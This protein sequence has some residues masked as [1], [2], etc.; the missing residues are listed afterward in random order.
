MFS[1]DKI[2]VLYQKYLGRLPESEEVIKEKMCLP[3]IDSLKKSFTESVEYLDNLNKNIYNANNIQLFVKKIDDNGGITSSKVD[4]ILKDF[5]FQLDFDDKHIDPFS[6]EYFD[7][8]MHLYKSITGSDIDQ[9]VTELTSFDFNQHVNAI[10]PYAHQ[11]AHVM[12]MHSAR[13][14]LAFMHSKLSSDDKLLDMGCGWGLSSEIG[15]YLGLN[16]LGIDIN[17]KFC[18]L[19]N[20]RAKKNNLRISAKIGTFEEI[21]TNDLFD[22]ILYYECLHHATKLWEALEASFI[23]LKKGGKLI[24]AGEPIN[25]IWKNW[26]LR[27][28]ALSM[29]CIGK[30]GWF[31]SGWSMEFLEYCIKKVGYSSINKYCYDG[32]IGWIVIAE[33]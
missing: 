3:N 9:K 11:P 7:K 1:R 2:K 29:Y 31:E 26:G 6:K 28:D 8:Q 16:V 17:Q 27:T 24:L 15:A 5:R 4:Q 12:G 10:N 18:E 19:I 20:A 30:H 23:K 33:K 14:S 25:N 21:P 22:G 32:N 13:L